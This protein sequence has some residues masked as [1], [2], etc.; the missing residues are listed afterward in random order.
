MLC[1]KLCTP[2]FKSL[3]TTIY[4]Y[5]LFIRQQYMFP[6]HTTTI[7]I[8][9]LYDSNTYSL[10][11]RQHYRFHFHTTTIHIPFSYDNITD[12][13][14]IRQK[15]I[16]PF[17]TT[18][19]IPLSYDNNTFSPFIRQQYIFPF[20][21]TTI[22]IPFSYH[23]NTYSPFIRQQ[24]I[25]PFYTTT[26]HILFSYNNNT[27]SLSKRSHLSNTYYLQRETNQKWRQSTKRKRKQSNSWKTPQRKRSRTRRLG[28]NSV[29]EV[30]R[31]QAAYPR[32]LQVNT[33]APLFRFVRRAH[34]AEW[35]SM[36]GP[37]IAR[38]P[39]L[40]SMLI[41]ASGTYPK[42]W[43]HIYVYIKRERE[44]IKE[45]KQGRE[46]YR[47]SQRSKNWWGEVGGGGGGG[48]KRGELLFLTSN[49]RFS[50]YF[51]RS[52]IQYD[53]EFYYRRNCIPF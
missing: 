52:F 29:D 12:S 34:N 14:F 42:L 25:F 5:S 19:H 40:F 39:D 35:S 38:A 13:I 28:T 37:E 21:S 22:H 18:I 6:F 46:T 3:G 47:F 32:N 41:T 44:N 4:N 11:I 8:P 27:D 30:R 15:Y 9:L 2:Q 10:F 26:I 50:F 36:H 33:S 45:G 48:G 24:Y 53:P 16:F 20:H 49:S 43:K 51:R 31:N 23:N 7:H 17:H 1:W